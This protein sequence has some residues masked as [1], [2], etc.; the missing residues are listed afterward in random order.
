[1]PD[2]RLTPIEVTD[3][4]LAAL[5]QLREQHAIPDAVGRPMPFNEEDRPWGETRPANP[6]SVQRLPDPAEWVRK[7]VDN[8]S[9]VGETNY[10]QGITHPKR[11]PIQAGI[12]AQATYEARMR[13]PNVLKRREAGLRQTSDEEW[14]ANSESIGAS[15]LVAGVVN[16]RAK[17]ER[18]VSALHGRMVQHLQTIDSMPNVS[19]ADREN[20]MIANL[21]G[22]RAIKG[23]V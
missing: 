5:Q 4:E 12:A 20:R 2:T 8:L 17:I 10:R 13:D 16:R 15:R 18:K 1:M 21:R 9:A 7:Q 19:D 6:V 22:M 11:S 14:A 3:G 23:T